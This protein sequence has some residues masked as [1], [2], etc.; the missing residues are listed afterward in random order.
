MSLPVRIQGAVIE[1]V[2]GQLVLLFLAGANGDHQAARQAVLACLDA[3]HPRTEPELLLAGEIIGLGFH[4]RQA[5]YQAAELDRPINQVLRLRSGAASLSREA[6]RS[7]LKLEA[8]QRERLAAQRAP[9]Q[10][11]I[12]A[13]PILPPEP[14]PV[15]DTPV[16]APV[17]TARY[18][19]LSKEAIRRLRPAEQKRIYLER[20]KQNARRAQ[21]EQAALAAVRDA[22]SRPPVTG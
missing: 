13:A 2:L 4:V 1:T 21:A 18:E 5:L 6:Y 14:E 3:Y 22:A 9:A 15:A 16:A 7:L 19:H 20:M 11:D 17:E 8:L 12:A 10:P